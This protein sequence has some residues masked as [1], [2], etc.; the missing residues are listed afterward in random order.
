MSNQQGMLVLGLFMV[1]LCVPSAMALATDG[2][3]R[4][5]GRADLYTHVAQE[6]KAYEREDARAHKQLE[7]TRM[8]VESQLKKRRTDL[9]AYLMYL[10]KKYRIDLTLPDF[11]GV[12]STTVPTLTFV[13]VPNQVVPGATTT[14]TWSSTNAATCSASGGWLGAKGVSGS[15][16]VSLSAT[17]TY[18][19]LCS[20]AGGTTTKSVVVGITSTPSTPPLV[21]TVDLVAASTTL[22]QGAST[23][24]SWVTTHAESCVAGGGWSGA[25]AT[26]GT[27]SIT[28]SA[29]TTYT[30]TC[31][32]AAGTATTSDSVSVGVVSGFVP[33]PTPT[34]DL[35][36]ESSSITQGSSTV[37]T[38][39]STNATSCIAGNG[40]SGAKGVTGSESIT[41][42]ATTTY[43]ITCTNVSGTSTDSVTV[44]VVVPSVVPPAVPTVDLT[45][46]PIEVGAGGT[47]TLSW[48]TT[49]ATTCSASGAGDWTGS[50]GLSGS[51]V[52]TVSATTTYILVCGNGGATTT[53]TVQVGVVSTPAPVLGKVVV[54]EVVYDLDG[55]H[56]SEGDNEWIE[57]YNG[58]NASV[59]L[60]G[61]KLRDGVATDTIATTS[62]LVVP[63]GGY[64]I[65][66]STSSTA[67]FWSFAPAAL[68]INLNSANGIGN[69]LA[70]G[71][72]VLRLLNPSNVEQD[73]VS[74]EGNTVAF[75]P[76]GITAPAGSSIAR[77]PVTNDTDTV[78]DWT[79]LATPT[80]G[81]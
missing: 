13:A 29:T 35:A 30:L 79:V 43:A 39:T 20:G 26:T 69:G 34:V 40:W 51:Q 60:G 17:T 32:N 62:P 3:G 64:A 12:A 74:W 10:E 15:Q 49:D 41:P 25:R 59:D 42:T 65:V 6:V 80:P 48:T 71:G 18:T 70:D 78:A 67:G 19:L 16:V 76:S 2:H 11:C 56:G 37:L 5:R 36:V 50:K 72:D 54:S 45:A 63:A 58:T 24:L 9:C 14:L 77:V 4:D 1:G 8:Q 31:A 61:W 66:V 44:G 73:A 21:P 52:V 22:T 47:S 68:V 53:D 27:Q 57:I 81:S 7:R 55:T 38:W 23:T 28:P 46:V 75:T 33:P